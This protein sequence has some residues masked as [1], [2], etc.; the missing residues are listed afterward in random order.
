ME[1][2]RSRAAARQIVLSRRSNIGPDQ[3]RNNYPTNCE[4]RCRDRNALPAAAEPNR[5]SH[6][7]CARKPTLAP[8]H[9]PAPRS[10][11]YCA[12]ASNVRSDTSPNRTALPRPKSS[13]RRC[14]PSGHW[15]TDARRA[16]APGAVARRNR[17]RRSRANRHTGR[18]E[19]RTCRMM[20]SAGARPCELPARCASDDFRAGYFPLRRFVFPRAPFRARRVHFRVARVSLSLA[21][22]VRRRAAVAPDDRSQPDVP[23]QSAAS[24]TKKRSTMR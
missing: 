16:I 5:H 13:R 19:C 23:R 11:R 2:P 15:C 21:P 9:R 17:N 10:S 12:G 6:Y 14:K 3:R 18:A 7:S 20:R 4:C 1:R 22:D 8:I 24:G